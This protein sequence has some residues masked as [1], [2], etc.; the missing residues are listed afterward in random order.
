[1]YSY[2]VVGAIALH[3]CQAHTSVLLLGKEVDLNARQS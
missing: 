2:A 3:L 1:M